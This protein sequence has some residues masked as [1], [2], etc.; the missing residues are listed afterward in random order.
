MWLSVS[1]LMKQK[2]SDAAERYCLCIHAQ[3]FPLSYK[4]V[5]KQRMAAENLMQNSCWLLSDPLPLPL[6]ST[7]KFPSTSI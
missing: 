3:S 1:T 2:R 5:Y 4:H 7:E 6:N